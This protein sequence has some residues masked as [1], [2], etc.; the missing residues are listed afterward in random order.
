MNT[1]V[2]AGD[3]PA[4]ARPAMR[5]WLVVGAV[6]VVMLIVTGLAVSRTGRSSADV[7]GEAPHFVDDTADS[8]ID[9]SYEGDYEH[10]VG[11][12]VAALD[13][14]S[15]GRSDLFI[16]GGTDPAALYRNESDLGGPLRFEPRPA[17]RPTSPRSPAPTRSTS[18]ATG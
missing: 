8:G 1:T 7:A 2:T 18:T 9:H 14:D 11:G 5:R 17:R 12:G 3:R 4:S 13:C 10:F 6:V 16:A 15:D